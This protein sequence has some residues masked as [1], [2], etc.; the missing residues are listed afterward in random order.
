M[1]DVIQ[2]RLN[3]ALSD[4]WV[5]FFQIPTGLQKLV[6][7]NLTGKGTID[8]NAL[9]YSLTG[10]H[11]PDI[12]VKAISQRY[13]SGNLYVSSHSK[14]PFDLLSVTF[15]VDNRWAN[16][17]VIYEWL[18]LLH[19][20]K[21]AYPDPNNLIPTKFNLESYW[22][23]LGL[24]CLDEANKVKIKF[25]FTQAF[26]TKITG[27]N[28]DYTNTDEIKATANFAFSQIHVSYPE[29]TIQFIPGE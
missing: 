20:E 22:T 15:N 21:E 1:P 26:P 12:T 10:V 25:T 18:N 7:T 16:W 9:Q 19:D 13:A 4:K 27:I 17:A 23:N 6:K 2:S 3:K 28:Y 5:L 11:V 14:D 29:T 24:V 8:L